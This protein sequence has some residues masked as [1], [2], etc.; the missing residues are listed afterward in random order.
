MRFLYIGLIASPITYAL[1]DPSRAQ[2]Y[3][4]LSGGLVDCVRYSE[5]AVVGIAFALM[6]LAQCDAKSAKKALQYGIMVPFVYLFEVFPSVVEA[7]GPSAVKGSLTDLCFAWY[8]LIVTI[9]VI[10]PKPFRTQMLRCSYIFYAFA[11]YVHVCHPAA[12]TA[13]FM[14]GSGLSTSTSALVGCF[15]ALASLMFIAA[16]QSDIGVSQLNQVRYTAVA[17]LILVV[18]S[19]SGND[20]GKLL[21]FVAGKLLLAKALDIY[22]EQSGQGPFTL[23]GL[24]AAGAETGDEYDPDVNERARFQK[25]LRADTERL[26]FEK[27]LKKDSKQAVAQSMKMKKK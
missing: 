14:Y 24:F 11:A 16:T 8:G 2:V 17:D 13:I 7:V 23:F 15:F 1:V 18:S 4:K 3:G 20:F 6:A 22:L 10:Y 21:P 25:L 9:C 12:A 5:I 19:A 26:N 27:L